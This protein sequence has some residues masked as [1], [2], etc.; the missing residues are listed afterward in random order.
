MNLPIGGEGGGRY[1]DEGGGCYGDE[2]G[3]HYYKNN[4]ES[5]KSNDSFNLMISCTY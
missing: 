1:G 2:R 4:T 3:E 5:N